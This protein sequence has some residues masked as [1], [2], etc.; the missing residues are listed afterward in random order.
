[1]R[2][3][4]SLGVV[5][6][7]V[8]GTFSVVAPAYFVCGGVWRCMAVYGER[9]AALTGPT[10]VTHA[11]RISTAPKRQHIYY[12]CVSTYL[13]GHRI[14]LVQELGVGPQRVL[15]RELHVLAEGARVGDHLPVV[16]F[17]FCCFGI[18]IQVVERAWHARPRPHTRTL[19]IPIAPTAMHHTSHKPASNPQYSPQGTHC[20]HCACLPRDI[21]HLLAGLLELV[22]HVDVARGDERVDARVARV[23]HRV[24]ARLFASRAP[25]LW[26]T[27]NEDERQ[28]ISISDPFTNHPPN[29]HK[30][31]KQNPKTHKTNKTAQQ[32]RLPQ[33]PSSRHGP[34]RR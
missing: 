12:V 21:E 3:L 7:T 22:L 34:A 16:G 20:T 19:I 9:D 11:V 31:P 4:N 15:R 27:W 30:T 18:R 5:Y 28:S 2:V 33:C 29:T 1:M 13:D 23:L 8:S 25:W 17:G 14:D 6:P 32:T 24:P 26:C 10:P